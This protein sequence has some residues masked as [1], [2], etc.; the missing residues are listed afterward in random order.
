ML[1]PINI[2]GPSYEHRAKSLNAQRT[3]GLYPEIIDA[4]A[5]KSKFILN[6]WPGLK[7]FGT[8][9]GANRGIF[10]HKGIL[11]KVAG[12][13]LYS[14]D[15]N[16]NHTSLGTVEGTGAC[17]FAGIGSNVIICSEGRPWQY[18]GSTVTEITDADLETPNGVAHLN[19]QI[20]YDGDGGRFCTSD[21]GDATS[22]NGLNY[23]TAESNADNLLRPYVFNQKLYLMGEKT[24]EMWWNSGVGNPPFDRIEGGILPIGLGAIHSP[25]NN[26]SF[27]YLFGDDGKVY[28]ITESSKDNISTIAL[29]K[30]IDSYLT[31]DDAIGFCLSFDNQ[32]FYML[33]FPA[34]E[35]S[36]CY[37]ESSGQWF[38]PNQGRYIGN[39]HAYCYRK[40][41]IANHENG[42]LYELDQDTYDENG[43]NVIRFRTTGPLSGEVLNAPGKRIELNRFELIMETGVGRLPSTVDNRENPYISLS[44]STDGGKTFGTERWGTLGQQ[45]KYK[46]VEWHA[47]GSFYEAIIKIAISDPVY[48]SIHSANAEVS[49]GI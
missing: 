30:E 44:L 47:L 25:A 6:S 32:N 27:L 26:D 48:V 41:I 34:E 14:V 2:T 19:N 18:N 15:V 5:A 40:N 20:I 31:V 4:Q 29:S 24:I 42:D 12:T 21:V 9:T 37:S 3:V 8:S 16:G 46:K 13:T 33:I 39:Y 36:W 10:E 22:I 11:Y 43:T 45:G 49:T 28:R 35:K 17:M 7:S 23:A 1:I 38:E